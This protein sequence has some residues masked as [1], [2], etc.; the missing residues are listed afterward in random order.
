MRC[1]PRL[2]EHPPSVLEL[3]R[4]QLFKARQRVP[5]SRRRSAHETELGDRRRPG[6]EEV[7]PFVHDSRREPAIDGKLRRL[8]EDRRLAVVGID[9]PD[10]RRYAPSQLTHVFPFPSCRLYPAYVAKGRTSRRAQ[11]QVPSKDLKDGAFSSHTPTSCTSPA[12]VALIVLILLSCAPL[13]VGVLLLLLFAA[14]QASFG[15]DAPARVPQH[16]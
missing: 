4:C 11:V 13:C 5:Q 8:D 9:S 15:Q 2:S 16:T 6:G 1:V 12:G 10:H 3:E 14:V 7:A